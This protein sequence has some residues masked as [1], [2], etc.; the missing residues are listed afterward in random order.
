MLIFFFC[1]SLIDLRIY[2]LC[3]L[4]IILNDIENYDVT[5]YDISET[6]TKSLYKMYCISIFGSIF[7]SLCCFKFENKKI[8]ILEY[9]R[10]VVFLYI[11][12]CFNIISEVKNFKVYCI[13]LIIYKALALAELCVGEKF[14]DTTSNVKNYISVKM[15]KHAYLFI[16]YL[17]LLIFNR[18]Q[19]EV[20]IFFVWLTSQIFAFIR[21]VLKNKN[22]QNII[23]NKTAPDDVN[24]QRTF[25]EKILTRHKVAAAAAAAPSTFF[26][27]IDIFEGNGISDSSSSSSP[28]PTSMGMVTMKTFRTSDKPTKCA[29]QQQHRLMSTYHVHGSGYASSFTTQ[30]NNHHHHHI[31]LD[32]II[33]IG[34]ENITTS[35]TTIDTPTTP[36]SVAYT[37][38][39][40]SSSASAPSDSNLISQ[41]QQSEIEGCSLKDDRSVCEDVAVAAAA[42]AVGISDECD[43]K[44]PK[45]ISNEKINCNIVFINKPITSTTQ[46]SSSSSSISLS[47]N[48]IETNTFH[49]NIILII[50][51]VITLV[52][53]ATNE[54]LIDIKYQSNLILYLLNPNGTISSYVYYIFFHSLCFCEFFIIKLSNIQ[55]VSKFYSII[56]CSLLFIILAHTLLIDNILLP[57]NLLYV[58]L[59]ILS[60]QFSVFPILILSLIQNNAFYRFLNYKEKTR[61]YIVTNSGYVGFA[62]FTFVLFTIK[63]E[64]IIFFLNCLI[65]ILLACS[66]VFEKMW[67]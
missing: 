47:N 2:E 26:P 22:Q 20:I 39:S 37:V 15:Q 23:M 57:N 1:A 63:F 32:D 34:T 18:S 46:S 4:D 42:G 27:V 5:L 35:F 17:I 24:N 9:L 50:I 19:V 21:K 64:N 8:N 45:V 65:M 38:A 36:I 40:S 41:Q 29:Q 56:L 31:C 25:C 48:S 12:L 66:I 13:F 59:L 30:L 10:F 14:S 49:Y 7:C 61:L 52:F 62:I 6:L 3:Y 43:T 55:K 33:T 60:S 16:F 67:I 28:P 54:F 44:V 11:M 58:L 51:L 53:I